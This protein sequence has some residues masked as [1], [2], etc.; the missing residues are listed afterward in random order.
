MVNVLHTQ[1]GKYHSLPFSLS[2]PDVISHF[3]C[4]YRMY[5]GATEL[6]MEADFGTGQSYRVYCDFDASDRFE[7]DQS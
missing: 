7:E 5:F 4:M 1:S 2:L 3:M 6:R